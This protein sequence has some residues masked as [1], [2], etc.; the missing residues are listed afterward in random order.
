VEALADQGQA[1][2]VLALNYLDPGRTLPQGFFQMALTP[3]DEALALADWLAGTGFATGALLRPRGRDWARRVAAAFA[4]RWE[5]YGGRIARVVTYRSEGDLQGPIRRLLGVAA[6]GDDGPPLAAPAGRLDLEFL[7]LL[8]EPA[9]GREILARLRAAQAVSLPV[10]ATSQIL[11]PPGTRLSPQLQGLRVAVPPWRLE[12]AQGTG[13][14]SE[15][16]A[17]FLG[18]SALQ[19]VAASH[20]LEPDRLPRDPEGPA[21]WLL[22]PITGRLH[23]RSRVMRVEGG[24]TL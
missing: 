17:R 16:A 15:L 2:P 23:Y 5:G 12:P 21:T 6:P 14:V 7:V 3:E 24:S 20:C 10:L 22:D 1:L 9:V 19:M 11:G 18:R 4:A 13:S 8:A